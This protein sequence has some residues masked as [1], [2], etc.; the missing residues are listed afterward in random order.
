M[1][2]LFQNF[3][4]SLTSRILLISSLSPTCTN[5]EYRAMGSS[6]LLPIK[7]LNPMVAPPLLKT[8]PS[9]LVTRWSYSI[10]RGMRVGK[11]GAD[12]IK[13]YLVV[14]V[15]WWCSSVKRNPLQ[16]IAEL[17][18]IS[19]LTLNRNGCFWHKLKFMSSWTIQ[20]WP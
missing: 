7:S 6:L 18:L 2:S 16:Y 19:M 1:E 3:Y 13:K 14:T 17:G 4:G 11:M 20:Q 8:N 5:L 15:A 9:P 12:K 10:H